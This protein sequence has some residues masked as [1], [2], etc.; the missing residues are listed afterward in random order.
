MSVV[1]EFFE[2]IAAG[3]DEAAQI[4]ANVINHALGD[5]DGPAPVPIT[6]GETLTSIAG[7]VWDA[8]SPAFELGAEE[9]ARG[10][11][12]GNAYVYHG[13]AFPEQAVIEAAHGP[14]M[15]RGEIEM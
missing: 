3:R 7:A 10:L 1:R 14:E 11:I 5:M 2:A 13:D 8:M 15:E 4:Q 6:V 12:T 9:L